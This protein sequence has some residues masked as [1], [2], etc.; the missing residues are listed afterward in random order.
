M[1]RSD[2]VAAIIPGDYGK[3]RPV[4]VVQSDAFREL[5]SLTVLPL[6]SELMDWPL[7]R[8]TIQPTRQ[9]GLHTRSQIMI[10]KAATVP[11][12]KVRGHIGHIGD[13]TMRRV[14]RALARFLGLAA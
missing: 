9:N 3:P 14:D 6:T 7:F 11:L 2:L 1:N 13:E 4:L 5:P 8:I 12:T 10:D